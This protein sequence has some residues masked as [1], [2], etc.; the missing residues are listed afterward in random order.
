MSVLMMVAKQVNTRR[1]LI[2]KFVSIAR[3][4]IASPSSQRGK[5]KKRGKSSRVVTLTC[6]IITQQG[7]G[8]TFSHSIQHKGPCF[9]HTETILLHPWKG[10]QC[11]TPSAIWRYSDT[12]THVKDQFWGP[13]MDYYFASITKSG[14]KS[15]A[16]VRSQ[17]T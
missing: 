9:F 7:A 4:A 17:M 14:R 5:R 2:K 13:V 15:T 11:L 16:F 12:F 6:V 3:S 8:D 1:P 10:P